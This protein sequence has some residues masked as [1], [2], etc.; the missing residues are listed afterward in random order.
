MARQQDLFDAPAV[1]P[2]APGHK[3]QSGPSVDAA[4]AI[5]RS[6]LA[7]RK[8]EILDLIAARAGGMTADEVADETGM[9]ILY[10]RPRV[11][12]LHADG[13]LVDSGARRPNST[14]MTATVWKAAT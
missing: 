12:E 1:Y 8:R 4:R 13:L 10:A 7:P 2:D 5:A 3:A 6:N 11:A 14:G 9:S